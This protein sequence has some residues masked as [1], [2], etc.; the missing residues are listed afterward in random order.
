MKR[1]RCKW[2][3]KNTPDTE[4]LFSELDIN[5]LFDGDQEVIDWSRNAVIG[6]QTNKFGA[7]PDTFLIERI[8]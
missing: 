6:E 7:R 1:F 4:C 3:G 5:V 8:N 2:K